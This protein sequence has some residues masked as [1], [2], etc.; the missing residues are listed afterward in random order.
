MKRAALVALLP[1]GPILA[2]TGSLNGCIDRTPQLDES[3]DVR[4]GSRPCE[5]SRGH[6]ARRIFQSNCGL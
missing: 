3:P 4:S 1:F 2:L 5:N 6:R